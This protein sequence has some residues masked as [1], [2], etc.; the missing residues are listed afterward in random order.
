MTNPYTYFQLARNEEKAEN[1]ASALLYY[2]SSF[3]A[4]CNFSN[5]H[6]AGLIAKI[7][8]LQRYFRLSDNE[9]CVLARSYGTL[10]D[11]E[12]QYLLYFS[13]YG[14]ICGIHAVLNDG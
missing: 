11:V 10:T 5:Y 9:L 12:C 6:N 4:S 3:C 1:F 13:I 2:L 8:M 7:R 14:D